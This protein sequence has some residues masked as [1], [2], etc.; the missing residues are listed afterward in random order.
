MGRPISKGLLWCGGLLVMAA[1]A[2][3]VARWAEIGPWAPAAMDE[4]TGE[5]VID[6][7]LPNCEAFRA[8]LA[9]D[10]GEVIDPAAV[11]GV[12]RAVLG[13]LETALDRAGHHV[14]PTAADWRG[15]F[16]RLRQDAPGSSSE[17]LDWYRSELDQAARFVAQADLME[18]PDSPIEVVEVKNAVF[19]E[20]FPLALYLRGGTLGVITR[21]ASDPSYLGNHCRVCVAPLAVHEGIPGHHLAFSREGPVEPTAPI[22]PVVHEGWALYAEVLMLEQGYWRGQPER[23]LAALRMVAWRALRAAVDAELH[24]G[25]LD[26]ATA[27][28]V[29]R[30]ELGMTADAATIEL[31]R[32]LLAPGH[33]ASYFV[34]ASRILALREVAGADRRRFHD[35]LLGDLGPMPQVAVQVF[36]VALPAFDEAA[37]EVWR[38]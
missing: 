13:R 21:A 4:P 29:Y 37:A 27:E 31:T 14:D 17:V 33:K 7:P 6:V 15:V 19:E 16:E 9:R 26:R 22:N 11:G 30:R 5:L 34:G 32:H 36:D 12:A 25:D 10:A 20:T 2:S 23:E 38:M 18:L 3:Q 1:V 24:C 35:R 28:E 8:T